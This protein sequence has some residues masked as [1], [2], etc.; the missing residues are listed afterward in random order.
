[1]AHTSPSEDPAKREPG[2][3]GAPEL[4][5]APS[6]A[7]ARLYRALVEMSQDLIFVVDREDVIRYVNPAAAA[8]L[9]R[10]AEDVVGR[11]R[12]ELFPAE[13]AERQGK[14]LREVAESGRP[15]VVE[16]RTELA[17]GVVWLD[18][19]LI[20]VRGETGEVVAVAGV[21]RDTTAR[22]TAEEALGRSELQYRRM[23]D[24][25]ADPIHVV[26]A[27]LRVRVFN[28]ALRRWTEE[29]GL[30][31]DVVGKNLFEIFTFL[32][33]RVAEE[34]RQVLRTGETLVT[35]ETTELQGRT[36]LTEAR[37][38]PMFEGERVAG[39]LTILRDITERHRDEAAR[40]RA[41]KL[42]SIGR[43]TGG[44]AHDFNNLLAG[45]MLSLSVVRSCIRGDEE[46]VEAAE[47]ALKAAE[48]AK[49][50][51]AQLV[52]FAKGGNPLLRVAAL[53]ELIREAATFALAGSKARCRFRIA[54]KLRPARVD[55][56]QIGQV[57]QN[58]VSNADQ[59]MP[60]GGFIDIRA[61]NVALRAG[62]VAELG[63]GRY[64]RI[65][66]ADQG[67]GMSPEDLARISDPVFTAS[68]GGLGMGLA[69]TH[70]IVQKHGGY[71]QI[72]SRVGAGTCVR[73]YLPASE[74]SVEVEGMGAVPGAGAGARILVMDDEVAVRNAL[75][76]TLRRM[77]YEVE[78]A[79]DGAEAIRLF[80]AAQHA[81]R[82]FDVALLDLTVSGGMGGVECLRRLRALAPQVKAIASTGYSGEPVIE[83]PEVF[84]F[85]A[86]LAKPYAAAELA[87]VL[88][89]AL[90][91]GAEK[92]RKSR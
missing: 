72:E 48:R 85:C 82:P 40:V 34:Y 56:G 28:E 80:T 83:R 43:L 64:V 59:A 33:E 39:V 44:V 75:E 12:A 92:R 36:V 37:K 81:G 7:E 31:S 3:Q 13:T 23:L 69:I 41:A 55:P 20:P 21:S 14:R 73:I 61:E 78:R 86:S 62:Q 87:R 57:I 53:G 24:A 18:S 5:A 11:R 74:E 60:R 63:A 68:R 30:P 70:S 77:G 22:K 46:A 17:G 32:P 71:V 9:G 88:R 10:R 67:V 8:A 58:V 38:I 76:Q 42:E 1:M 65:S 15:S 6:A 52:T 51:A 49:H 79:G 84:G 90:E 54:E 27:D 25:M 45:I 89:A 35:E 19:W 4:G 16:T 29:F 2:P 50:L 66:V 26:D 47:N 91:G